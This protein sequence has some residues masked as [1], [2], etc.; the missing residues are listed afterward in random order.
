ML[1]AVR[2]SEG[3]CR[4]SPTVTVTDSWIHA[5]ACPQ[6]RRSP[7]QLDAARL[8]RRMVPL[9]QFH[10]AA[11]VTAADIACV[12]ENADIG[13]IARE[14]GMKL[15]RLPGGFVA[16]CP[17]HSEKTGSFRIHIAGKHRGRFKCFGCDASGDVLDLI[18]K[19]DGCNLQTA[20]R[21]LAHRAGI[22]LTYRPETPAER[23]QRERDKQ[24]REIVAWYF[25]QEWKKARRG[26]NRAMDLG[27]EP[28]SHPSTHRLLTGYSPVSW[29][30]AGQLADFYGGRLRWIEANRGT[31]D[32]L[33]EFRRQDRWAVESR[34]RES[35]R[36]AE[37]RRGR[38]LKFLEWFLDAMERRP[39][40][41]GPSKSLGPHSQPRRLHSPNS[42]S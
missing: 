4:M 8:V 16:A 18:Q 39:L 34:Y 41:S 28:V 12:T 40:L 42:G 36:M 31:A 6:T 7:S 2:E 23:R 21:T 29:N 13:E 22:T 11:T 38:E 14:Y 17:F 1:Q 37:L 15:R 26:L 27:P 19:L 25:R 30:L 20:V 10:M 32:G 33:A 24:E 3:G 5:D 35:Q 9:R